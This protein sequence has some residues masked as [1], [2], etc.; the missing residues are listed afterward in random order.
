MGHRYQRVNKQQGPRTLLDMYR[1]SNWRRFRCQEL[2]SGNWATILGPGPD[3]T[4]YV[5]WLETDKIITQF[6]YEEMDWTN[7]IK[8]TE[9]GR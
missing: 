8:F 3:Y 6:P 9:E 1:S 2:K 4:H 5:G 7:L